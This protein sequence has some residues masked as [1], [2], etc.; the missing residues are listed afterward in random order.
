[1]NTVVAFDHR[2]F[3]FSQ[4]ILSRIHYGLNNIMKFFFETKLDLSAQLSAEMATELYFVNSLTV[5]CTDFGNSNSI[6]L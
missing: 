5:S 4:I 3:L 6:H 1:M 2:N